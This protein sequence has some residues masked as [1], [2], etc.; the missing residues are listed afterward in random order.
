MVLSKRER[1]IA[2]ATLIAVA[3]LL[4]DHF[5]LSPILDR[6]A[7]LRAD[8]KF[9]TEKLG[10][11]DSLILHQQEKEVR[12]NQMIA[13]GLKPDA[14]NTEDALD[15]AAVEWAQASGLTLKSCTPERTARKDHPDVV[16]YVVGTGRMSAVAQFLYQAQTSKLPVKPEDVE[17]SSRREATDDL[18]LTLH[19]SGFYMPADLK[20]ASAGGSAA[21]AGGTHK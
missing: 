16:L 20:V 3:V 14:A 4:L 21:A 15:R 10:N 18:T 11:A 6:L 9:Y 13:D 5:A 19:L 2:L 1:T 8:E 7:E 12:W 17:I